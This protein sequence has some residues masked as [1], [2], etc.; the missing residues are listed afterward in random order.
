MFIILKVF[1]NLFTADTL[2]F[3]LCWQL[4]FCLQRAICLC[5]CVLL[6]R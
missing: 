6:M 2:L 1:Y 3:E 4:R 5:V